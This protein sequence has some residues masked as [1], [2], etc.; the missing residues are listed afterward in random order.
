MTGTNA[1]VVLTGFLAIA[2]VFPIRAED[3]KANERAVSHKNSTRYLT[4]F[5][6]VVSEA[7]KATVAVM[8]EGKVVCLGTVVKPDGHIL[9]K[10]SEIRHEKVVCKL[11]DGRSFPA[12]IVGVDEKNDL[13]MIKID[14]KGLSAVSWADSKVAEVGNWVC[15]AGSG[16]LPAAAGVVS[17]ATREDKLRERNAPTTSGFMGVTLGEGDP[18]PKV[19][20]VKEDSAAAKA[21]IKVGDIIIEV[22]GTKVAKAEEMIR[23]LSRTRPGDIVK[24]KYLRDG[25][26]SVAEVTL[27]KR[28]PLGGNARGEIQNAM[29]GSLSHFKGPFEKILQHDSAIRPE[30]CGGPLVDL[31][32]RV[33]GLNI[34]RAGRVESYALPGELVSQLIPEFIAGKYK[35]STAAAKRAS[36]AELAAQAKADLKKLEEGLESAKSRLKEL[37]LD[38]KSASINGD[39]A[40]RR[41]LEPK[42][43]QAEEDVQNLTLQIE[44]AQK[45]FESLEKAG[46]ESS[47]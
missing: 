28:P 44:K 27:G 17:V 46:K 7:T 25:E 21:G 3:S 43:K 32:G 12:A 34:A 19:E 23:S 5:Q 47:R 6:K 37:K 29:G 14:A 10:A 22:R 26:E 24:L 9:T 16:E 30:E 11:S 1:R 40:E 2:C 4:A 42:V 36:P 33:V 20:D 45:E 41:K 35:V 15:V 13:A 18:G 31:A 39:R 38:L 8:C